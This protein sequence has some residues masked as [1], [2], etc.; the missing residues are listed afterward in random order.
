MADDVGIAVPGTPDKVIATD[1]IA[2][3]HFQ[4]V[5]E[6]WGPD[7]TANDVDIASGKALPV[8]VRSATGLIPLGEP[9]DAKNAA[10]DAT[11][12]SAIA[13]LKQISQSVQDAV[14]P[15]LGSALAA[16]S[17]PFAASTEDV[18]R[19]GV[20]T[21]TAPVND[22][23]SS[24]LN[25]R[26]QRIAQ[27]LTSLI[28]LFP[29]SLGSL[30]AAS[31]LATTLS[32]EDVARVGVV[33][34]TAPGTDTASSGLN[35]RLQRIAQRLTSLIAL[36]PASLGSKSAATSLAVTDSTEDVARMGAITETAPLTDIASSGLN[37]RLQRIA[38]RLSSL[39][40]LFPTALGTTTAANSFPVAMASDGTFATLTGAVTETA[41]GTD[42]ASSGL[43]GRLQRIAQR[44]TS[45]IALLPTA[46]GS[47]AAASSLAVTA[48]TEDVARIGAVTETAPVSDIASSGLNGRLQ[49]VAQRLTS[50]IAL[51][52]TSLGAGGGLKIDGSGTP[53][54]VSGTFSAAAP[55]VGLFATVTVTRPSN[56]NTYQANDVLGPTGGGTACMDFSFTPAPVSGSCIEIRGITFERD[57][58]ALAAGETS[59]T[60]H[61]YNVTAP[62]AL[63]DE[64]TFDL[65]S[66]DR[67]AYLGSVLLGTPVDYGATLFF[68][69]DGV[70][71]ML[72]LSGTHLFAYLVTT[73]SYPAS[74]ATVHKVNILAV[75]L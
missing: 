34:E 10:T 24:G 60:L 22:T 36:L 75:Q 20:V 35:G 4:R 56:T 23:A 72:K 46:L 29:T 17:L 70:G 58:A 40:A 2:G 48:S 52:P 55:Q 15:S 59:Y 7:G 9:T 65:P 6:T 49:R 71:K 1:E 12:V 13:L 31:S 28:G 64:A 73:G 18:A 5:K 33:A 25:G 19:V 53:I 45:L 42:I 38:Q 62:S 69:L 39:I 37:G 51:M 26:L 66:G 41:P 11:S 3:R 61:F 14:P 68:Q 8:Q 27:R 32:T 67:A 74:S 16:D 57:V 43:N 30:A 21:E 63:A 54:A 47:A 50:L 44:L